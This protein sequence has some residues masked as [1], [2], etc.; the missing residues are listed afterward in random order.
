MIHLNRKLDFEVIRITPNYYF[1][2]A[3]S[4]V[5]MELSVPLSR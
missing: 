4:T 5:V 3:D 1:G 2:P